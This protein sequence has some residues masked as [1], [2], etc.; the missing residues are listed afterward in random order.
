M[1]ISALA[2]V[3]ISVPAR[4]LLMPGSNMFMT[5]QMKHLEGC[6]ESAPGARVFNVCGRIWAASVVMPACVG[7]GRPRRAARELCRS[8]WERS[9]LPVITQ[10]FPSRERHRA[11]RLRRREVVPWADWGSER[12]VGVI[13]VDTEGVQRPWAFKGTKK[14]SRKSEAKVT[15]V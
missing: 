1:R 10:R 14:P 3:S 6:R 12:D 8:R 9:S 15:S 7:G 4:V 11:R 2:G 13:S 5:R